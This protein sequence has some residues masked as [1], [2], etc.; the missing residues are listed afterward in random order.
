MCKSASW[1][2]HPL[3][4]EC[5]VSEDT[6]Q[7]ISLGE[8]NGDGYNRN[9]PVIKEFAFDCEENFRY[10]KFIIKATK[11]LPEWHYCYT[12]NSWMFFDEIVVQ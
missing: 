9:S 1:I 10:I 6:K 5:K 12:Y 2:L 8:I 7:W 3:S 4:V 11:T